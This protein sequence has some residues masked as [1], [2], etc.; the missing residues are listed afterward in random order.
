[1]SAHEFS[2][3]V[4]LPN[5][6]QTLHRIAHAFGVNAELIRSRRRTKTVARARHELWRALR[7]RGW[8]YPEIGAFTGHHHSAVY[9][10]LSRPKP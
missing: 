10:A 3:Q 8:S 5:P 2:E 6:E 4:L 7:A 1:M 9:D